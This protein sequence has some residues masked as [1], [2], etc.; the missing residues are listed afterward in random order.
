MVLRVARRHAAREA[1]PLPPM[2]V[3]D[4]SRP[5]GG[6]FGRRFGALGHSGRQNGLD[7]GHLLPASDGRNAPPRT[8]RQVDMRL[9][10]RL[11]DLFVAAGAK[12]VLVGPH[13]PLTGPRGVVKPWPNH[14]NHL[15]VR[16]ENPV[17]VGE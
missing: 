13:L 9:A 2:L 14:D 15:H 12:R 7:A 5:R 16:I 1:V 6:E 11:V 17:P 4:L 3:G 10:Q 8:V